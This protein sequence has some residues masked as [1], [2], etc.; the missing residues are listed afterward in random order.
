MVVDCQNNKID[1][2]CQICIH[3]C[4]NGPVGSHSTIKIK[5][6]G[7]N[8]PKWSASPSHYLG[9]PSKYSLQQ[10]LLHCSKGIIIN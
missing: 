4:V 5:F 9:H 6:A 1:G 8:E 10:P 2:N 3:L 7:R